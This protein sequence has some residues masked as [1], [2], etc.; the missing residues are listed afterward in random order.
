MMSN[1]YFSCGPFMSA[2]LNIDLFSNSMYFN[3]LLANSLETYMEYENKLKTAIETEMDDEYI[4]N[5][6][7]E[8]TYFSGLLDIALSIKGGPGNEEVQ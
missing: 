2:S 4:A 3:Y 7:R 1:S 8:S 5:L 6:Q